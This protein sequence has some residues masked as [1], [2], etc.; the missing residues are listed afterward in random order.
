VLDILRLSAAQIIHDLYII[1]LTHSYC[2]RLLAKFFFFFSKNA[3]MF[4][5]G[6]CVCGCVCVCVCVCVSV[7]VCACAFILGKIFEIA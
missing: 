3:Q 7:C 4:D 6:V 2:F 1:L 5:E